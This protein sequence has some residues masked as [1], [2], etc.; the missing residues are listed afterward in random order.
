MIDGRA[1]GQGGE[2]EEAAAMATRPGVAVSVLIVNWNTREMTLACLRSLFAE[3]RDTT[4]EVV[5]VDNGSTDGSAAAI[6]A[7]FPQVRLIAEQ[8]NHGFARA[9]NIAAAQARGEMLLLLNSDTVVLERAVD[10]LVAFA[11]QRPEAGVWG[12]RTVFAD[13]SLNIGSA[14][15]EQTVWSAFCFA[16]GLT[17][18]FPRLNFFNPEGLTGWRRDSEREVGI[19]SGCFLLITAGL[20]QR[21][22]GFDPAFFMYGEEADLC[23]R[24]RNIGARPRVTPEATIVHYGGASRVQRADS[25]VGLFRAKVELARRWM[26]PLTANS[27]KMLLL[28]SVVIRRVSYRAAAVGHPRYTDK[29]RLWREVLERRVEWL[30]GYPKRHVAP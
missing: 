9:N 21:L 30:P 29:A 1:T 11:R 19:V 24:A 18:A 3:T 25:T 14:W 2:P 12:G 8:R 7:A 10:R 15:G 23:R 13:G 26:R 6:A 27:V 4:F 16:T 5:L 20:W 28:A 17:A 22:D